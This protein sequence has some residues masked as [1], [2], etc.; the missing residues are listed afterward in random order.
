MNKRQP[1]QPISA[2]GATCEISARQRRHKILIN[3]GITV[4]AS[5]SQIAELA[6]ALPHFD[7]I[8]SGPEPLHAARSAS[9]SRRHDNATGGRRSHKGGRLQETFFARRIQSNSLLSTC[10]GRHSQYTNPRMWAAGRKGRERLPA[11]ARIS[12]PLEIHST[13]AIQLRARSRRARHRGLPGSPGLS[14]LLL[15]ERS[16]F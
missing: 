15:R 1:T 3:C 6:R 8:R 13:P 4:L 16:K 7:S 11:R 5:H 9:R 12:E 14:I 2:P 10:H